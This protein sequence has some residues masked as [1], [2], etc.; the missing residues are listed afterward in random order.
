MRALQTSAGV[1]AM[2][3]LSTAGLRA[4]DNKKPA[5]PAPHVA[6]PAAHAPAAAHAPSVP[7]APAGMHMPGSAGHAAP[8]AGRPNTAAPHT[9]GG[10]RTMPAAG[11]RTMPAAGGRPGAGVHNTP[12]GMRGGASWRMAGRGR[13]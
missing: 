9:V 6:A 11:G 7:H 8:A 2:L 4:F 12:A 5:A 3:L 1:F 13:E 10:G